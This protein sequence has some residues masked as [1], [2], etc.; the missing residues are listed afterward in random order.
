M[1]TCKLSSLFLA[2]NHILADALVISVITKVLLS[3]R[4]LICVW[5]S[6]ILLQCFAAWSG[7]FKFFASRLEVLRHRDV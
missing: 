7:L 4:D 6:D 1:L 2:L 3:K 5:L